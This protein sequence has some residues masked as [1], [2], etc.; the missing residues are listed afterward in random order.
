MTTV[1]VSARPG[2]GRFAPTTS[3]RLVPPPR[4]Q[5]AE[6]IERFAHQVRHDDIAPSQGRVRLGI[7]LGTANIVAAAVDAGDSPVAG[8]WCHSTVVRDGVVVDWAGAVGAVSQLRQHLQTRL[9][10][11]FDTACVAIPPGISPGTVRVF[12]NVLEAAGLTP[13]DVIDE[14]VAAARVLG[15]SDGCVIDVGHGTTGVSILAGGQVVRSIDEPTGGHHMTLVLAGAYRISYDQAECLKRDP[16]RADE[17]FGAIRATVEKMATIAA[18]AID[19]FPLDRVYLVGGASS[20]P[21]APAVFE[22][23]LGLPVIRPSEPMFVTPLGIAM[24]GGAVGAQ[25]TGQ[26]VAS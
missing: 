19:G 3:A 6:L 23:V 5:A 18:R 16:G 2:V 14:P 13:D 4:P 22:E 11:V 9:G 10:R 26:G 20:M 21:S 17:V 12:T 8:A 1:A 7:D 15:L 25:E 24:S